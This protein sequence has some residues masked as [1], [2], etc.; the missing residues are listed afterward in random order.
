[1]LS[2]IRKK[3]I[4]E[5][6]KILNINSKDL[7]LFDMALTHPSYNF[8]ANLENA[9]DYERL[10]FLGDSVVRLV[11]SNYLYD[12]YQDYD[13]G[14]LTKIRSFLVSDAFF[15]KLAL[16]FNTDNYL[17]IGLHEEKDGG[18]HKESILACIMEA[19]YGAVFISC[20]FE[21][22][23][24]FIYSIYENTDINV[25]DIFYSYNPKEIL[26]EYTQG[27]HKNLPEYKLISETGKAHE[28]TYNVCVIYEGKE[29][30]KG[31]A[32][33][34]KEAEKNAAF[35]AIKKLNIAGENN[36]K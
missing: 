10:E 22:A 25:N 24:D 12:K 14:K 35:E 11:I 2:A 7:E 8:E 3:E 29:L 16:R 4:K 19:V 15:A 6:L 31:S 20:G 18:R 1:M 13:E 26:Q 28:K 33:S 30:G 21:R 27:L 5:F 36:E 23:K 32:K 17:K 34:K 9:P